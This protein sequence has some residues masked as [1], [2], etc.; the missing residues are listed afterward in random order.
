MDTRRTFTRA[1]CF[2][3]AALVLTLSACA[4][5][6]PTRE[7]RIAELEAWVS[8]DRVAYRL[9]EKDD[10]QASTSHKIWGNVAHGAEICTIVLPE[11]D[12]ER[13]VEFHAYMRPDCSF[14]NKV[15]GPL[16]RVGRIALLAAGIVTV[17][18]GKQPDWYILQHEQIHFAIA[19]VAARQ[20]S[21]KL[22]EI[23]YER[24]TRHFDRKVYALTVKHVNERNARFDGETSGTYD[25]HLL[26]KWVR[27]LERELQT[28]C[29]GEADDE[30][31]QVRI[32]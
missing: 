11:G 30:S 3:Q 27:L 8:D 7:E 25:P 19:E 10:F 32:P 9:L 12:D 20:L 1:A 16:G 18:G 13:T 31:C 22:G 2:A 24:R 21:R 17:G 15:I 29:K 5:G 26:E 14:W 4:S 28:L 6:P 23:P